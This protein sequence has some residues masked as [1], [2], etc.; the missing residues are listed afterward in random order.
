MVTVRQADRRKPGGAS[1]YVLMSISGSND[2]VRC[3]VHWLVKSD[4]ANVHDPFCRF[5]NPP[6][7]AQ[8]A[9]AGLFPLSVTRF[10]SL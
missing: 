6:S 7:N 10:R 8:A 1:D 4:A 3:V 9:L 2:N 5:S